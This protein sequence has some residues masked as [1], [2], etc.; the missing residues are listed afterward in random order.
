MKGSLLPAR[1]SKRVKA[2]ALFYAS[3]YRAGPERLYLL[4]DQ[5]NRRWPDATQRERILAHRIAEM[6]IVSK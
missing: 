5:V 4:L 2:M 3:H 1:P 6:M